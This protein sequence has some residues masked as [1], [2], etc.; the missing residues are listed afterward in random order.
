MNPYILLKVCALF[1]AL[2]RSSSSL[3]AVGN[4][5]SVGSSCQCHECLPVQQSL[6][7]TNSCSSE[8]LK[9][10]VDSTD[11]CPPGFFCKEGCCQCGPYT[12]KIKCSGTYS[13]ALSGFCVTYDEEND[14]VLVGGCMYTVLNT[15]N[16]DSIY[17]TLPTMVQGLLNFTCRPFNRTGPLCGKCEPQHYPLA[18]SFNLT[19]IHCPGIGLGTLWQLIFLLHS[20]TVS[21]SSLT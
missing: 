10:S 8:S 3:E 1:Y 15:S 9:C 5:T 11:A 4:D 14:I 13:S 20:S 21:Y 2:A 16:Q 17:Y 18:Y 12:N 6:Q 7:F 19:C